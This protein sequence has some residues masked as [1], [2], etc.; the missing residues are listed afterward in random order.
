MID[1]SIDAMATASSFMTS[2]W[3]MASKIVRPISSIFL[4]RWENVVSSTSASIAASWSSLLVDVER[5][6]KNRVELK[7][8]N[9][10]CQPTEESRMKN[11]E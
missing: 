3:K 1:S 4:R 8:K 6:Q 11:E 7:K 9:C 5:H 10:C 2:R